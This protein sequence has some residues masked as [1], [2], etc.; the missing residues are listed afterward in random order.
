M[1]EYEQRQE[2][3]RRYLGGEKISKIARSLNKS[4]KWAHAWINRFKQKKN[5]PDWYKDESKAPKNI[6]QKIDAELEQKILLI[7][8]ELMK[9]KMAQ[10]GAISIQY[11]CERRDIKPIPDVW[12]IQQNNSKAWI[13]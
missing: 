13:E 9:Q 12:T 8:K 6:T 4:R 5:D 3:I 10:I 11:E 7:R 2:A 1:N